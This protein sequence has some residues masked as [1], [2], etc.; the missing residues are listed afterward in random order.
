MNTLPEQKS[1][2]FTFI[3]LPPVRAV[4]LKFIELNGS[5]GAISRMPDTLNGSVR[6]R[7]ADLTSPD[8]AEEA[9]RA[10]SG[11]TDGID[12][13]VHMAGIYDLG[14]L[15]EMENEAWERI[16]AV[17]LSAA[18][19]LNRAFLPLLRKGGRIVI[20]SSELAPLDPLP[21]TGLYGITKAALEKY[22]FS[23]RMEVQLLGYSVIVLRPGAVDTGLL[24]VSTRRL[25]EFCSSTRLYPRGARLRFYLR[26]AG[27]LP[28]A[29]G[30]EYCAYKAN[31]SA[32]IG[33]RGDR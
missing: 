20:V 27:Q 32:R 13:I 29:A 14:S 33:N 9:F 12:C 7:R 2:S 10:V 30:R 17:N 5:P 25:E 19:R 16:F 15:A 23:L 21:F 11:M 31:C 22:A 6:I 3:L 8:A 18:Y 24:D 28:A 4:A 26:D 1:R